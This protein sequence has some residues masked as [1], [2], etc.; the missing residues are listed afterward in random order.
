MK[1]GNLLRK[2]KWKRIFTQNHLKLT[3]RVH[4]MLAHGTA[5]RA[6]VSGEQL[7]Y[8]FFDCPIRIFCILCCPYFLSNIKVYFILDGVLNF[9]QSSFRI[10]VLAWESSKVLPALL[11]WIEH[12][13][14]LFGNLQNTSHPENI[15]SGDTDSSENRCKFS[16]TSLHLHLFCI[17][18]W[19]AL[20]W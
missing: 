20:Q 15:H 13:W 17:F 16:Q 10:L 14:G 9:T 4:M 1:S 2:K 5:S 3:I 18:L 7:W 8:F 19:I 6:L 12:F 11:Q